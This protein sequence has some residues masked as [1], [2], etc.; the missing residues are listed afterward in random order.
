MGAGYFFL[1]L[2]N[3]DILDMG[4]SFRNLSCYEEILY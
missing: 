1:S 3:F 2:E 4:P